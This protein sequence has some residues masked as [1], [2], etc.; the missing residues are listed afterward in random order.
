MGIVQ[1]TLFQ[2]SKFVPIMS[3]WFSSRSLC[4]ADSFDSIYMSEVAIPPAAVRVK[5]IY[6]AARWIT[7]YWPGKENTYDH[8]VSWHTVASEWDLTSFTIKSEVHQKLKYKMPSK[9]Q[10][11]KYPTHQYNSTF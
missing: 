4:I 1:R 11:D 5:I 2:F 9:Y 6:P 10:T 7:S 3:C 8:D